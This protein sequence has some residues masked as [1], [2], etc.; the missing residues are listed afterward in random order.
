MI[1]DLIATFR[2]AFRRTLL[3]L[4]AYYAVTVAIPLATGAAHSGARFVQHTLVVLAVP[5]VSVALVC[6]AYVIARRFA[7]AVRSWA[8]PL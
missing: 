8:T 7:H 6:V 3:P 4:A 1:G 5:L 2:H